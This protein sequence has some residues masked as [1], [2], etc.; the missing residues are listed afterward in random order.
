MQRPVCINVN[1]NDVSQIL[2]SELNLLY[3]INFHF[4]CKSDMISP[5]SV[6]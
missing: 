3:Y 1:K 4:R 2:G 6:S 5:T